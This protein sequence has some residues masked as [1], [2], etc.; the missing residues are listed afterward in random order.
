ME[1]F[2]LPSWGRWGLI[3]A[4]GLLVA[5]LF[6]LLFRGE[7]NSGTARPRIGFVI[8]GDVTRPG[9][10][11]AHYEGMKK[12]CEMLGAELLLKDKVAE[13]NGQ[14]RKAVQELAAAGANMIFLASYAYPAEV[15]DLTAEY[16]NI[17]F[18]TVSA[19]VH[20]RNMTAYFPRLYQARYLSGA[21]A[22]MRSKTGILGYVG[23]MQNSEVCRGI[24]AFTLGARRV[25]PKARVLVTWTGSWQD[26]E[27]ANANAVRLIKAGAD[28]LTFHQNEANVADVAE[29][30]GIDFIG[31]HTPLE[32]YSE[33]NLTSVVARWDAFY[34]VILYR[35]LRGELNHTRNFWVGIDQGAV[36]LSPYSVAVTPDIA[37]RLDSMLQE[38]INNRLIFSGVLRDN[39]GRLRCGEGEAISD[40][41]LLERMNWLMEGVE[42]LG[43]EK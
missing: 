37:V 27:Q 42:V 43:P 26:A 13:N 25:N 16:P 30:H 41:A 7:E 21:L 28:V 29:A 36:G 1:S 35:F 18:A 15:Q 39:T 8:I 9:Y 40:D 6:W 23:A 32:G 17:A 34:S 12:A 31:Y 2:R 19:E 24:N 10:N 11:S 4:A 14:C 22:A 5:A 33:H 38:L 20:S 3:V